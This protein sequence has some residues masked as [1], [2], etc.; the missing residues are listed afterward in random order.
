MKCIHCKDTGKY[1]LPKDQERFDRLVDIEMDK[2]YFVNYEIA[3]KE[4]YKKV[5]YT[6]IDCPYC[7]GKTEE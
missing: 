6:I 2:A 5:G 1:K 3:E 7:Q 4:A